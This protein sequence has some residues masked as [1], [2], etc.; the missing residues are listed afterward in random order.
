MQIKAIYY[1]NEIWVNVKHGGASFY[2]LVKIQRI[3]FKINTHC[4]HK[5]KM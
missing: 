2:F 4:L 5:I 3:V 1:Y